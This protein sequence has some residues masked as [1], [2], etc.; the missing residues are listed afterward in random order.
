[1]YCQYMC[2]DPQSLIS[3]TL[4]ILE[5]DGNDN[6]A[7]V[8]KVQASPG[9]LE[10][11]L[12]DLLQETAPNIKC[13]PSEMKF[14]HLLQVVVNPYST[15]IHYG[16]CTRAYAEQECLTRPALLRDLESRM[17]VAGS[18]SVPCRAYFKLS[19]VVD[20]I[21]PS[22][23]FA[24]G[25]NYA[26]GVLAGLAQGNSF[27]IDI[28]ASPGGWTQKLAHMGYERVLAVDPGHLEDAVMQE[29]IVLCT[30]AMWCRVRR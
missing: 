16:I 19:E 8:L 22:L 18:L 17:N 9:S 14:T 3:K 30:Y 23:V 2:S 29:G 5:R 15:C 13:T 7:M 28:G 4:R 25:V 12:V 21:F 11:S 24:N 10:M 6:D 1:M 20:T 27:A 26:S